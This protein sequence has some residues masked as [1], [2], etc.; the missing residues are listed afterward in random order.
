MNRRGVGVDFTQTVLDQ[1]L[2]LILL[3]FSLRLSRGYKLAQLPQNPR[4]TPFLHLG[5]VYLGGPWSRDMTL[6]HISRVA[7]NQLLLPFRVR[8]P[9]SLPE[10]HPSQERIN[11]MKAWMLSMERTALGV[12]N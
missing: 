1:V 12:G 10:L 6:N 8:Q 4:P 9:L 3:F 7:T 5:A 2:Y 11:P